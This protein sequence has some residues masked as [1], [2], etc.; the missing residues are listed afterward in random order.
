MPL[1]DGKYEIHAE[2]TPAPGVTEF[3]ATDPDGVAVRVE[4]FELPASEEATFERYRRLLKNLA[5]N[6]R[7]ALRDVVARP[8]ARYVAWYLPPEGSSAGRDATVASEIAAAGFDPSRASLRRLGSTATLYALPFWQR[9]ESP[10]ATPSPS[11]PATAAARRWWTETTRTYLLGGLLSL[12]AVATVA[13]GFTARHNDRVV[14]V[15]DTLGQSYSEAAEQLHRDGLRVALKTVASDAHRAGVVIASSPGV[16][17]TL[18]PGRE[19][20]LSVALPAGQL[21]PTEVPQLVGLPSL[22]RAADALERAGLGLGSV[23]RV[24]L[25]T[26]A[27]VVVAQVPPAQTTVGQGAKVDLVLSLGPR[28]AATFLP[29]LVGLQREEAVSLALLAGFT[30]AQVVIDT[31]SGGGEPDTVLAQSIAPYR[32][33]PVSGATLRLV[34][35]ES[36][37]PA[38]ATPSGLPALGGMNEAQA[39][40]LAAGFEIRVQVVNDAQLPD[41]VIAQSL[42]LGAQP[43]DGPLVLTINSRPVRVPLPEVTV[44]VRAPEL[45]ALNY[46]WFIEPGILP[47][48]AEVTATTL[49]GESI[50]VW[51]GL[52]QGGGRVS[53]A[54]QTDYPGLVR[55][56]LT[57]NG[58]AYGGTLRVQ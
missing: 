39:R 41:G 55:F 33:L 58:V 45:R 40:E 52:A 11:A 15:R 6:D 5:R 12:L 53:G 49:E 51:Q 47:S 46:L 3:T 4:W 19:V 57:L 17:E 27:G 10:S 31:V 48:I 18:R 42:P 22:D 13:A 44:V 9:S 16:G 54:W 36:F 21:T 7:A 28:T 50:S 1:L 14:S 2:R 26:P 56:D 23:Q 43:S 25:D 35:A 20:I 24:H 37:A 34:V 38:T 32:E 8:G 30:R 29:D